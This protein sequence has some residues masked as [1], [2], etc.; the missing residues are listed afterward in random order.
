MVLFFIKSGILL[1]Y[2]SLLNIISIDCFKFVP[3]M[4]FLTSLQGLKMPPKISLKRI[5]EC[6]GISKLRT[7]RKELLL[8]G[9]LPVLEE[10]QKGLSETLAHYFPNLLPRQITGPVCGPCLVYQCCLEQTSLIN[11]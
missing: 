5:L 6:K 3:I 2:F 1:S 10:C 7:P 8:Q 9:A 11:F 4:L